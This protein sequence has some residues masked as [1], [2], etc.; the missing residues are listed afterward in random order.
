MKRT[1][2]LVHD[3]LRPHKQFPSVWCPGCGIGIVLGCILRAVKSVGWR[4]EEVAMVSGI[5]CSGR[6]PVYTD[7]N[8]V[9]TTH[10]RALAFATGL[11]LAQPKLNVI[12]VMGDGDSMAIGGNH[13]IHT[14]RRN[15]N[16]T[17]IVIN[18]LIYGMTGGQ[19]SPTTPTNNIATTATF[20]NIDQP[21]DI[22]YMATTAGASFVGRS[23]VYHVRELEKI[24]TEAF[25]KR[26][27]AMVEAL[28]NCHTYYGRLNRIGYA[29]DVLKWFRDN[30][31]S[32]L[33]PEEKRKGKI[34]RGVLT[35]RDTIGF[36]EFYEKLRKKAVKQKQ[37]ILERRAARS[38]RREHRQDRLV[39]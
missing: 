39:R 28:S 8:T 21:F 18:N 9:H 6:M 25:Q 32:V 34:T 19:C 12:V 38:R 15:V 16:L 31:A 14:C 3:Y 22:S 26:G 1:A 24:I 17:A 37:K 20:G 33:T 5:G 11:K 27:F 2:P 7:F 35:D 23:T 29:P 10:G 36:I 4:K 13:F 30:T